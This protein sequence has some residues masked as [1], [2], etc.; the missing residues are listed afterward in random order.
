MSDKKVYIFPSCASKLFDNNHKETMI[1]KLESILRKLNYEVIFLNLTNE[2]CGLMYDSMGQK[3]I[4]EKKLKNIIKKINAL[5]G[6][7]NAPIL[8][9]NSSCVLEILAYEKLE[10]ELPNFKETIAFIHNELKNYPLKKQKIT[11]M[12]H[13]NCSVTKLKKGGEVVS[14][15]KRCVSEIII[16]NDILCCGFAG[17]KGFT[18]PELNINALK[19]LREQIPE[20]CHIGYTCLETCALGFSKHSG[21]PYSSI[22][23]L[24]DES[25]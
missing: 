21:I 11:A 25:M 10:E 17:S 14:L 9:E 8:V 12:L 6:N 22:Y 2:C 13:V 18:N 23:H 24:L 3:K 15:A 20:S 1:Y 5:T 16:P 19:N 7:S 4:A